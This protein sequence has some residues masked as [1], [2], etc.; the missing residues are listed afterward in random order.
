MP[1]LSSQLLKQIIKFNRSLFRI[2]DRSFLSFV[3]WTMPLFLSKAP[4]FLFLMSYNSIN[5]CLT[6]FRSYGLETFFIKKLVLVRILS[7]SLH[8]CE[9]LLI[10][11]F[12]LA[13]R[14]LFRHFK[15]RLAMKDTSDFSTSF[16]LAFLDVYNI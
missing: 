2:V 9:T 4:V 5:I 6:I 8:V 7:D 11:I 14:N 16:T 10:F 13:L 3:W 1:P 12:N 15:I